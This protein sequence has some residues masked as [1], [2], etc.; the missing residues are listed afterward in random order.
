MTPG[1]FLILVWVSLVRGSVRA[2]PVRAGPVCPGLSDARF[3]VRVLAGE[4]CSESFSLSCDA[5]AVRA[6]PGTVPTRWRGS[7]L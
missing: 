1:S 6:A 4:L 2:G 3:W 7:G 5:D